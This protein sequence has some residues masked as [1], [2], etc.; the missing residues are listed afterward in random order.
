[1][2]VAGI[3]VLFTQAKQEAVRSVRLFSS[4]RIALCTLVDR[5]DIDELVAAESLASPAFT[6]LSGYG[7]S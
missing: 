6:T 1:M 3:G 4:M 2:R 5:L 7:I